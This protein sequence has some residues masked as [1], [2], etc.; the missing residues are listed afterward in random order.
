MA[1][2]L[3]SLAPVFALIALGYLLKARAVFGVTFWEG[4]E[5]LTFYFLFPALLVVS[6][7]GADVKGLA[8]LPMAA[9]LAAATLFVAG[10]LVWLRPQLAGR[11]LDGAQFASVLQG[12]IRPNTY[13]AIAVLVALYGKAGLPLAA[14]A[15]VAVIPLVNF[16]GIVAHLRWA[17]RPSGTTATPG[18]GEAVV[19]AL[20]NPIIVAC[21]VGA[22]LNLLGIG[23]PP[24]VGPILEIVGRAAL[25]MGLM[26]VGAGLD[27]AA[28]RD[29][30]TVVAGTALLKLVVMPAAVVVLCWVFGVDG[31][32]RSAAVLFAAMPVSATAYVVSTQMGGDSRLMAGVVAATTIAAAITLP[33]AVMVGGP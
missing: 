27:L 24:V 21:L 8:M 18:W 19:P 20:K 15:I 26:A 22:A 4:A 3:S 31:V 10:V 1:S 7:G 32:T 30:R 5:R 6:I 14:V 11:G 33:L 16:L 13:V 28:A 9:A 25:P 29:A 2:A 23:V 17:R 12:A